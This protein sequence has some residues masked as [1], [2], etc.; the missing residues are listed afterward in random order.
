MPVINE[1]KGKLTSLVYGWPVN[2]SRLMVSAIVLAHR[3]I[4][5]LPKPLRPL[6]SSTLFQ[7]SPTTIPSRGE[8]SALNTE[9]KMVC[10]PLA[11]PLFKAKG[12]NRHEAIPKSTVGVGV[13][14][15]VGLGGI[16]V[17]VGVSLAVGVEVGVGVGVGVKVEVGVKVGIGV[18][19]GIGVIVGVGG[20]V[21]VG[22]G[23][24]VTVN[25][26]LGV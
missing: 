3:L 15:G 25:V 23:V 2:A 16:G 22:V 4:S 20:R 10:I 14:V 24:G 19:V 1:S 21:W 8:P 12:H 13:L 5:V 9:I 6:T 26:G 7:V 18:S 17:G 11:Q